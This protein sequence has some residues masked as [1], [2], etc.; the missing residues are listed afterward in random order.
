[1]SNI[2]NAFNPPESML[3][4]LG[5]DWMGNNFDL[6]AEADRRYIE[7]HGIVRAGQDVV[8]SKCNME[9]RLHPK[10]QGM[11]YLTRTCEGIFK[12]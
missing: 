5:Y 4:N 1:M 12:L 2:R 8:C 6:V 10:V 3:Q 7:Q 9:Y 11:L